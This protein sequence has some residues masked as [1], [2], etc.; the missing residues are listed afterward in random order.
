MKHTCASF[1]VSPQPAHPFPQPCKP[2]TGAC[3]ASRLFS[4]NSI[5][6][7]LNTDC[8]VRVGQPNATVP[9]L[10]MS[11]DIGDPF[12]HRPGERCAYLLWQHL[13]KRVDLVA[14][15]RCFQELMCSLQFACKR[16]LPVPGHRL[17]YLTQAVS[18][19]AFDLGD[20]LS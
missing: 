18:C 11:Y 4:S 8:L 19:Y 16:R 5:A 13:L 1:Q 15:P 10:T 2:Q 14:D 7:H 6:E 9:R 3:R 12:A 20:L 17:T